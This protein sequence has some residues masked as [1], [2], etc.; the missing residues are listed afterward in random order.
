[1]GLAGTG[2]RRGGY[3]RVVGS[4]VV[5]GGTRRVSAYAYPAPVNLRKGFDGLGAMASQGLWGVPVLTFQGLIG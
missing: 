4:I 5:I 3:G 2:F 1:V